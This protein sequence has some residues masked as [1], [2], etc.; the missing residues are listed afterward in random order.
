MKQRIL[1][2][3]LAAIVFLFLVIVGKLPFTILIYAMGSVALF[4]L[5]RMKKLKLVSLP[6]LIGLLLLWMFLL[7][8][9]YSF[10]EADGIS[11]MEIALFAVL[12]LLTYTVLVKNTF[13][14]DEVGFITLAAIYIGM[15]FHYF[16]EIRNL[17]QYGLTYIF[18]ACVVI[19]STDSGAYFVGK[20]LGK[21]KLWPE[22][23]PNKTVEGFAGGIVIALVLA[24]IFQLVAQL[25]IPYIYL[26]LITLF[27]SVFGQLGDLVE[28]ALK[29]HY[30]VKDSGNILPGH[31]GILD[32]F[33][34]FLFVMPFLYFLL[35]LFHKKSNMNM[36]LIMQ[37]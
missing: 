14:F 1:T 32:R 10:F 2:G 6:G 12:L 21:R 13:T 22:I 18:Y 36:R 3:V 27:L 29:R 17:D 8:S 4:E 31:G 34:S 33:D 30:D 20:S 28:S 37:Q 35:A 23:S 9:Q 25:P 16:I 26:L 15:C 11:K 19:W 7:P 5:L 24:T